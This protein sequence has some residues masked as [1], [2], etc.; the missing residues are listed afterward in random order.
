MRSVKDTVDPDR[1]QVTIW[2]MRVAF[3]ITKAR[4]AHPE[5]VLLISFPPQ[6]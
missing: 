5:Y 3:W 2:R 4:N 1:P 6:Q